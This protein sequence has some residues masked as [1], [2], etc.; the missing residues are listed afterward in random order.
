MT[1]E[2]DRLRRTWETWA[3]RD[4]QF[5][6][7]STAEV[8]GWDES[9]FMSYTWELDR[10]IELA[11]GVGEL[12]FGRALDFGCGMG[13]LTQPLAGRFQ[14]VVGLDISSEMIEHARRLNRYDNC[15]YLNGTVD[16]LPTAEFDFVLSIYVIQ[17]IPGGLQAQ[18]LRGLLRVLKP[19][20]VA[21]AVIY[22]GR[23]GVLGV[24]QRLAPRALKEWRFHRKYPRFPLIEMNPLSRRQVEGIV[25]PAT[26]LTERDDWY[27]IAT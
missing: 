21:V 22:S 11:A 19:G 12:R 24:L 25:A 9:R 7:I 8:R 18:T 20:G 13:R 17:H 14:S 15:E 16:Q 5:A 26:V 1:E 10:A 3:R 6:I 23:K 27:V 2:L 4:R